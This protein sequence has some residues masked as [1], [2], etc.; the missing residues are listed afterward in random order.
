MFSF[1]DLGWKASD[2][3]H[4]GNGLYNDDAICMA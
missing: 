4:C 1:F 2:K 3:A